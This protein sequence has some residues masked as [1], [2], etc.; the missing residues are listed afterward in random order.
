MTSAPLYG[1]AS[2]ILRVNLSDGR[3]TTERFDEPTLRKYLGGTGLGAKYLYEEVPANKDW[4]DPE[5][6]LF[7]GCGPL[8][9]T[10]IPGSGTIS[11]VSKGTLTNGA[12]SSQAGGYFGAYLRFCGFDG[13]VVQ[14][15][16][17]KLSYLY[18]RE[19]G[20]AELRDAAHLAGKGTWETEDLIKQELGKQERGMS[21]LCIGPAGENLVK[22]AAIVGDKGHVAGRNG[23]GAV[24]GSKKLKA[25]A[26]ARGRKRIPV[27]DKTSLASVVKELRELH[28]TDKAA[29]GV[30]LWGTL[31]YLVNGEKLGTI[32]IKNY[33]TNEFLI[34]PDKWQKFTHEYIREHFEPKPQPCWACQMHHSHMMRITEGPYTG[35][36][37]EE[38]EY[39]LFAQMG[40]AIGQTDVAAAMMLSHEVDCLGLECD[41]S[42]WVIGF[43]MECYEKGILS[44]KDCDGLEMNWGNAEATKEML[45][46]IATRR[47][48]GDLLADGVKLAGQRIGGEAP[49]MGIYTMKG[50][51]PRAHDDRSLWLEMFDTL[52]SSTSTIETHYSV[53]RAQFGLPPIK[54]PFS[55]DEVTSHVALTKGSMQFEDSLVTCRHNTRTNITL[56]N[57][58]LKAVTGWDL[59]FDESMEIGRRA[60]NIL[61]AF[62]LRA[63]ITAELD[64]PSPR[65]GS[66]PVGGPSQGK[67]IMP[68]LDKMLSDYYHLMGWDKQ[69]GKPLPETL[70][71][72]GLDNIVPDIWGEDG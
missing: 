26:V 46:R 15:A 20:V 11:V 2:G 34:E 56:L 53:P 65:Y 64:R 43:V 22:F 30:Y 61:R 54:D 38:P 19:D 31:P 35:M 9:G 60:I 51:T 32:P 39:Q 5:N 6:R 16:A 52:V 49:N 18:I 42:G 12:T 28:Q 44:R 8:N 14:G 67:G 66:T 36:V 50:N 1:Y 59:S 47:G 45:R 70:R 71:R 10:I 63:G 25:I 7:I 27:K 33:T 41:E 62:N 69:S 29:H 23:L 57:R 13:I 24:M 4:S 17:E 37:V 55:P 40:P 58:A 68:L 21:V 48:L 3:V 72:L